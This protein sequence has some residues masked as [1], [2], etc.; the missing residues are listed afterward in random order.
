MAAI[1]VAAAT[2]GSNFDPVLVKDL[3]TKV[4][5]HSSLA[6]LSGQQPIGFTGNKYMVFNMP[7]EVDI[8]AEGGKKSHG[9]LTLDP[10]TV[11]PIKFE[12]GARVSDEFMT[13]SEEYQLEVLRQF[14]DGFAKKLARGMDLA[15]MHGVNPRTGEAST[16]VG[17]N[18][19]DS[20][21][22]QKVTYAAAKADENLDAAIA[23]VQGADGDVNGMALS[24]A[25]GSAMGQIKANGIAQYPEFRFGQKP[26]TFAGLT[27]DVNKT[28]SDAGTDQAIVGDFANAF[29]WGFA[30]EIPMEIIP[31]GDPDNSGVDLKGSNQVYIRAEAYIGWGI[32]DP[33]AFARIVTE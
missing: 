32:L 15:G 31:Y 8:V 13:A 19:F 22:S 10:V 20:K 6:V 18:N 29:R 25:F 5:G 4:Q 28:V 2:M 16:V 3:F 27:C 33:K 23:M 30:K 24:T 9:G 12:Y 11:V 26:T 17:A 21:V 1:T 14:N 7:N